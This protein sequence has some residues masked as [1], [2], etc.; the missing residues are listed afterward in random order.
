[1]NG[2]IENKRLTLLAFAG[3]VGAVAAVTGILV[4]I[5]PLRSALSIDSGLIPFLMLLTIGFLTALIASVSLAT[6]AGMFAGFVLAV[7][8]SVYCVLSHTCAGDTIRTFVAFAIIMI[9]FGALFG[10][11]GAIPV[12]LWRGRNRDFQPP[13]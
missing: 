11:L 8:G 13:A 2:A 9:C 10:F 3:L 12:W 5:T 7:S 6:I 4:Q 1:M